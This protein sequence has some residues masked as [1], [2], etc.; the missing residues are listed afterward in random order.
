MLG[1]MAES[2]IR[3][4]FEDTYGEADTLPAQFIDPDTKYC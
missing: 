2:E 1:I 3:P 4:Y